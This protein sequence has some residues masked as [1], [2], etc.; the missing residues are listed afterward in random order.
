MFILFIYLVIDCWRDQ[1][2]GVGGSGSVSNS[3]SNSVVGGVSGSSGVSNN[4]GGGRRGSSGS[5]GNG[6]VVGSSSSSGG[7]GG[8]NNR[9]RGVGLYGDYACDSP[10]ALIE[11][12]GKAMRNRQ[13]DNIEF[14]LWTG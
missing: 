4:G 14:V 8:N 9:R 5:G 3:V 2:G 11:S 1:G 7:S 13:G 12:A 10:W 6:G